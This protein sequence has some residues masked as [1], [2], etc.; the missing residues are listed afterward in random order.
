MLVSTAKVV[1]IEFTIISGSVSLM[2]KAHD[3]TSI[4]NWM[5]EDTDMIYNSEVQILLKIFYI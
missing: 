3:R 4:C 5:I 1:R 2:T